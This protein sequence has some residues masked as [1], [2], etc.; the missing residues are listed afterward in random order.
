M[1][2]RLEEHNRLNGFVFVVAEFA[3]IGAITAALAVLYGARHQW[4]GLLAGCGITANSLVVIA[5]VISQLRHGET[6]VG[7]WRVYADSRVRA[8]VARD[9]PGLSRDTV[10]ITGAVLVPFLLLALSLAEI[11]TRIARTHD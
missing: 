4:I 3:V 10:M 8:Q 9:D 1:I 6:D 5:S 7:I 2:R 11:A